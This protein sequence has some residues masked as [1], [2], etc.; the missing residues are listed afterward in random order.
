MA[1]LKLISN[2]SGQVRRET[3][4]G[5]EYLVAPVVA[6]RAGVLNGELAPV[7]EI[8]AYVEAWNGIP[9]ALGHPMQRGVPVSANSPEM[10]ASVIVGRFWNAKMVDDR[11]RGEIWIDLEKA[12]ALP[13]QAGDDAQEVVDRLTAGEGI[14]VSTAY[15][16]DI[17][18]NPGYFNGEAYSGIQHNLR[19]D[20]LALLLRQIGAC[21]WKDGCGVPRINSLQNNAHNGVMVALYP[22][23]FA[24][25]QLALR[26]ENLPEGAAATPA[27]EMHLTLAYLGNLEDGGFQVEDQGELLRRVMDW[28]K[29]NT[30]VRGRVSG[31]GRFTT[32]AEMQALVLL[33]DCPYLAGMRY[34]LL[35]S[36]QPVNYSAHGF[37][38]HITL[39]YLPAEAA[40]PNI[41]PEARELVFDRVG[42][43]WGGQVTMFALQGEALTEPSVGANAMN[44]QHGFNPVTFARH[45]LRGLAHLFGFESGPGEVESPTVATNTAPDGGQEPIEEVKSMEREQL[46]AKL[47]GNAQCPF[48]Q[49]ELEAMPDSAL[50]KLEQKLAGGCAGNTPAANAAEQ[51]VP[52]PDE[53]I[54]GTLET[55]EASPEVVALT[56][57]MQELGGV[58][59]VKSALETIKANLGAA[60]TAAAER[61][62]A[63]VGELTANERCAFSNADLNGM[64]LEQLEK[65]A[66]SLRPVSYAG[67]GGPRSNST[68]PEREIPAPPAIVLSGPEG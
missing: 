24:A 34:M 26:A 5:R 48:D 47:V 66:A 33:F 14:E 63:L 37:I 61:K 46:I 62:N 3:L 8:G 18:E 44:N 7:D 40:M 28:A 13:G 59:G 52:E 43:A 25:E 10:E 45:A 51:E 54:T 64:P 6:I 68:S 16:R 41:V 9:V 1:D 32:E 42:V 29:W 31:I 17:E 55:V 38:P 30:V 60:Q 50:T 35:D 23:G 53:V 56:A 15:W 27:S 20:H 65:L 58:E 4:G 49:A 12:L 2:R 67:R 21:S 39:A 36:L 19:P 11:L 22:A 57:L